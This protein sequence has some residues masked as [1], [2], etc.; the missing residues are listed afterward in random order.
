MKTIAAIALVTVLALV[1]AY[2]QTNTVPASSFDDYLKQVRSVIHS[3]FGPK[4]EVESALSDD[5]FYILGNFNGDRFQD[6]AVLVNIEQARAD[7][8]KHNV[9]FVEVSPWSRRNGLQIDPETQDSHNCLGVA[10]IHGTALG[11]KS[12]DTDK[13]MFYD[14]FSSFRLVR[15]G[16]KVRRG[17]GSQGP[18]PRLKGDAIFLDLESGATAIVYWNGRSYRGFGIRMGD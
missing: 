1:Q 8:R 3:G 6:I 18:T 14:C 2:A 13:F 7:L 15:K 12:A 9:R 16:H 5:P 4:V 10:I 17:S 11:W